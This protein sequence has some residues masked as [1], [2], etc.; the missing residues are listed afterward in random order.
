M[1]GHAYTEDQLVEQP[2]MRLFAELG[3]SGA[4]PHPHPSPLPRR[5]ALG[6]GR[7]AVRSTSGRGI[8][9]EGR[10]GDGSRRD[11]GGQRTER[12]RVIDWEKH[13]ANDFL[14]VSQF[15]VTGA[16]HLGRPDSVGF[17][18]GLLLVVIEWKQPGVPARAALG[19]DARL[20]PTAGAGFSVV[21]CGRW[22]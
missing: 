5:D 2:A 8:K 13:A 3:W 17:V 1:S 14:L 22:R 11:C 15:S 21:T 6:E 19:A 18:N 10:G 9:G 7:A 4:Q 16:L 20:T 12:D